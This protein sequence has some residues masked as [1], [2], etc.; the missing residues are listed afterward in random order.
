MSKKQYNLINR[1]LVCEYSCLM[2]GTSR[3][4]RQNCLRYKLK[5]SILVTSICPEFR[6]RFRMVLFT[7]N[8]LKTSKINSR[9][10]LSAILIQTKIIMLITRVEE[11]GQ[12][13]TMPEFW[14]LPLAPRYNHCSEMQSQNLLYTVKA[15]RL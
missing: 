11:S 5:N 8:S 3:I 1:S 4:P 14:T 10:T 7:K 9:L 12:S 6:R 2:S 15:P 13:E